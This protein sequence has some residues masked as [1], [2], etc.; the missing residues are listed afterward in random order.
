MLKK[1]LLPLLLVAVLIGG[2][3]YIWY[4]EFYTQTDSKTKESGD[5]FANLT[6]PAG[7][8]E[9]TKKVYQEKID[10]TKEMYKNDPNI[11]ETWIG[12][13]N[14]KRM[15]KDYDGAI[16][17]Y[18]HSVTIQSNNILGYPNIAHVYEED[19]QDYQKAVNY[20][21]L[22]LNNRFDD[23]DLYI[24]L[25]NVLYRRLYQN[26]EAEKV[27]LDGLQKTRI[28]PDV[29]YQLI[30]FYKE[31]G[32]RE[33]YEEYVRLARKGYPNETRFS[34]EVFKDVQ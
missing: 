18:Q 21:R 24:Q 12:I 25:G 26:A 11:W 10:Q 7:I 1:I 3:V 23:P 20:Y 19:L 14:L 31:T 34:K 8:D 4:T 33:K 15:L 27:Y 16:S 30:V 29:V 5:P 32:N 28:H 13:G 2:G 17:A 6:I 22:A 9:N